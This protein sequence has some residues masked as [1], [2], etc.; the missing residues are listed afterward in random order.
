M[1]RQGGRK[2][3]RSDSGF[4]LRKSKLQEFQPELTAFLTAIHLVLLFIHIHIF[5]FNH[6]G[7]GGV[8]ERLVREEGGRN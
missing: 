3:L 7:G 8:G 2:L 6:G 1:N 4:Q 5:F